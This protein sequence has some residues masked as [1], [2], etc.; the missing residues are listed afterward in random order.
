MAAI[1]DLTPERWEAA[2]RVLHGE[3]G[4]AVSKTA[5]AQAAGVSV[6]TLNAWIRRS[7]KGLVEDDSWVHQIWIDANESKA[8]QANTLEDVAWQRAVEG[9]D[10]PVIMAGKI[11]DSYKKF[12]NKIL[13][14]LL[15]V[16]NEKYQTTRE[17]RTIA[18]MD[19]DEV[20]ERLQAAERLKM[21]DQALDM[22]VEE[23]QIADDAD[24]ME[25][26]EK[27]RSMTGK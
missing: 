6:G 20:F 4:G 14:Q 22:K 10:H 15:A 24:I 21:A 13:M 12:D 18:I 23:A 7:Q 2:R 3:C 9:W 27:M 11:T 17:S 8:A 16:R 5:A 26:L 25:E 19:T 1:D